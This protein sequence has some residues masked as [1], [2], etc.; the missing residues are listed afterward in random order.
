[1]GPV[2]MLVQVKTTTNSSRNLLPSMD[3]HKN[4]SNLIWIRCYVCR[5]RWNLDVTESEGAMYE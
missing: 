1:M 4:K 2:P 5:F 3:E